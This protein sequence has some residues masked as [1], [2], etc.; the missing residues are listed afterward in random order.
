MTF[1]HLFRPAKARAPAARRDR[2][3]TVVV[4]LMM[5]LV[6]APVVGMHFAASHVASDF[7]VPLRGEPS[8][9]TAVLPHQFIRAPG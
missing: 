8:S 6:F 4:V 5:V 3:V 9:T 1:L 7:T 2:G